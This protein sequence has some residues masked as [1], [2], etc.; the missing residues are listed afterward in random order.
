[1]LLE[2]GLSEFSLPSQRALTNRAILP[3]EPRTPIIAE[4]LAMSSAVVLLVVSDQVALSTKKTV[5]VP[6][7][8][9]SS[10][11]SVSSG[12]KKKNLHPVLYVHFE[13]K[14][15]NMNVSKH[16]KFSV[17]VDHKYLVPSLSAGVVYQF[18][19]KFENDI[20]SGI[21]SQWSGEIRMPAK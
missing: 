11:S 15:A 21:T 3:G 17:S 16:S 1:M 14:E 8:H 18:R 9:S 4:V 10:N 19:C 5:V 6:T 12:A 2:T 20:G 7:R 13:A